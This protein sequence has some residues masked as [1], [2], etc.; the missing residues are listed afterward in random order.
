M[1]KKSISH[2]RVLVIDNDNNMLGVMH[3][4]LFGFGIRYITSMHS[5]IDAFSELNREKYNVVFV[6]D[7]LTPHTGVELTREL[8]AADF[9]P[10]QRTP[11]ILISEQ[12][13]RAFIEK[14]RDNGVSEFIR[15]PVTGKV[16]QQRLASVVSNPRDFITDTTY[17]GP[18]RRRRAIL[19]MPRNAERRQTTR[20]ATKKN[21]SGKST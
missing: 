6:T 12:A 5:S 1:H 18:D 8:R 9:S 10:N 13:D 21:P 16:I 20:Q 19:D 14:A 2:L 17:A 3:T 11:V 4:F 7:N 15:K